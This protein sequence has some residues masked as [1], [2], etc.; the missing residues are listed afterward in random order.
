M[1]SMVYTMVACDM[2][3]SALDPEGL[4]AALTSSRVMN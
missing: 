3:H 4:L 2:F 1:E